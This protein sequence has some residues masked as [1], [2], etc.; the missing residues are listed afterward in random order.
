MPQGRPK[1]VAVPLGGR[2]FRPFPPNPLPGRVT[3]ALAQAIFA[4]K[5]PFRPSCDH[6]GSIGV[7][8]AETLS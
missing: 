8:V 6:L 1:K 3:G 5:L 4:L 2:F 7:L